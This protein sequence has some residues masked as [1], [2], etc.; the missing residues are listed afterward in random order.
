MCYKARTPPKGREQIQGYTGPGYKQ[1]VDTGR[2]YSGLYKLLLPQLLGQSKKQIKPCHKVCCLQ[3]HVK[4]PLQWLGKSWGSS[5]EFCACLFQ[6][7]A[8]PTYNCYIMQES[9]QR[10]QLYEVPLLTL[11]LFCRKMHWWLG[12]SR[13]WFASSTLEPD[14]VPWK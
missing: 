3:R 6:A 2:E 1:S 4:M 5:A 13:D 7:W 9:H 14:A 12:S 8:Y 11:E 10:E